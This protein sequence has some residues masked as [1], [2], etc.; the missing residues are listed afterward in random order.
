MIKW[1]VDIRSE[2]RNSIASNRIIQ[3][4]DFHDRAEWGAEGGKFVAA[5][6][7]WLIFLFP[8]QPDPPLVKKRPEAKPTAKN[9]VLAKNSGHVLDLGSFLDPTIVRE[10]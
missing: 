4:D 10:A 8:G 7:V 6:P 5:R 1:P 3:I 9:G 2:G